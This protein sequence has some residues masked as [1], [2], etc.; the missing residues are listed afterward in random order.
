MAKVPCHHCGSRETEV[1]DS[2][3][4]GH[5]RRRRRGCLTCSERW[6]TYEIEAETLMAMRQELESLRAA[7]RQLAALAA[8][9]LETTT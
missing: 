6:T 4:T 5:G 3:N 9:A 8:E 2:R 7:R 1:L